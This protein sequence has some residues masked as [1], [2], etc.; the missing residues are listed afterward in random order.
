MLQ[1]RERP[2]RKSTSR[3]RKGGSGGGVW[4]RLCGRGIS[5]QPRYLGCY[6][7]RMRSGGEAADGHFAEDFLLLVGALD[8]FFEGADEFLLIID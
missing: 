5:E 4:R 8:D 7:E 1:V 2:R 3:L 6:D